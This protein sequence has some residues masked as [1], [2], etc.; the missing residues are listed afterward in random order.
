MSRNSAPAGEHQVCWV[1]N[2]LVRKALRPNP[3]GREVGTF[4]SG[5]NPLFSTIVSEFRGRRL[6]RKQSVFCAR[7]SPIKALFRLIFRPWRQF[8]RTQ[9][10]APIATINHIQT[11]K[12]GPFPDRPFPVLILLSRLRLEERQNVLWRR[13]GLG[14]H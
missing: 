8:L 5:A 10:Y 7:R 3:F 13:V 2:L 4:W 11:R 14:E 6:N 9:N 1:G 12:G